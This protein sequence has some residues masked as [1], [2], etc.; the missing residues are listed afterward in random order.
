MKPT[1]LS[2]SALHFSLG[3]ALSRIGGLSREMLTAYFL[4]T[5]PAL[6]AF[7]VAFR[8]AHLMRRIFAEGSLV[9]GFIPH[10]E[11]IRAESPPRA[12]AF[13]RDLLF[14]T[15]CVLG[16]LVLLIEG[17]LFGCWKW[18]DLSEGTRQ[19]VLLT[20]LILPG[21]PFL[22]LSA[23]CS[24]LVQCWGR[25][26]LTGLSPILF[27]MAWIGALLWH[28]GSHALET[29]ICLACA[30][31][32]S[33][34]MQWL[35]LMPGV[36]ACLKG[37]LPARQWLSCSLFSRDLRQLLSSIALSIVGVS[38]M[39][40]NS[41]LDMLFARA[42]S[43]EGPAY[44]SYAIRLQQ[45]PL[46]LF[47][48]A[49]SSAL[50]P[51]LSRAFKEGQFDTY[52]SLLSFALLRAFS[53]TLPCMLGMFLLGEGGIRL[54]YERGSFDAASSWHTTTCLWSYAAGLIPMSFVL[55]LSPAFYAAKDFATPTIASL[56][57]IGLNVV[58]NALLIFY[59]HLGA[60]SVALATS[61]SC[62]FNLWWLT[63]KLSLRVGNIF[64]PLA[65]PLGKIAVCGA[66]AALLSGSLGLFFVPDSQLLRFA[67]LAAAFIGL[68]ILLAKWLKSEEILGLLR[69]KV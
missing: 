66:G 47:G 56:L 34:V 54:I 1:T 67:T 9:N 49:I 62:F 26:F 43:L 36:F 20:M 19:I 2:K 29:T 30:I 69:K 50:L 18:M 31:S 17:A 11:S 59:F 24:G 60:E 28:R 57:S 33:F 39:Q 10:F 53:F 38:A 4:G 51:P 7:L 14:S 23:L 3:T 22:C 45:L 27:N 8:F 40:I 58:L 65:A 68:F 46:A 16:T 13:F 48:I 42:A 64:S 21:L 35:L 37:L 15:A 32:V 44:L 61:A 41:F 12:A 6:G 5:S 25:F 55:L 52:R 63:R